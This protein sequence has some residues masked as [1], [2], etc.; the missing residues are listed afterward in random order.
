[1][2]SFLPGSRALKKPHMGLGLQVLFHRVNG[3]LIPAAYSG[4]ILAYAEQLGVGFHP[5]SITP[6]TINGIGMSGAGYIMKSGSTL[7]TIIITAPYS[8][9]TFLNSYNG[10]WKGWETCVRN[11]DLATSIVRKSYEASSYSFPPG[12]TTLTLAESDFNMTG[13]KMIGIIG[14]ATGSQWIGAEGWYGTTVTFFNRNSSAI[15]INYLVTGLFV[16]L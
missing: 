10:A 5:I 12:I 15:T 13:Y 8:N 16:K 4:D 14:A 1:M 2:N 7:I 3:D 9:K 6:D 11:S